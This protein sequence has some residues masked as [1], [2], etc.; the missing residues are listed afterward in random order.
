MPRSA[1]APLPPPVVR[2]RPL[3]DR[4]EVV[5]LDRGWEAA[6]APPDASPEPAEIDGLDWIPARVPGTA[7]G[8][9]AEAGRWRLGDP[10]D[11]DREDWW[12]RTA[13]DADPADTGEEALLRL[14]GLATVADVFLNGQRIARTDSM[15]APAAANVGTVLQRRNELAIRC[16][17]LTPLLAGRRRPRARWRTRLVDEPNLRFVRTT[18]LGRAPGYAPGPAPVGPWRPVRLERRRVVAVESLRVR[19]GATESG[20]SVHITARLRGLGGRRVDSVQAWVAGPDGDHVA[21]L[22]L[23]PDGE[24]TQAKGAVT[25]AAAP[26]WWPHTHGDP[27]TLDVRLHVQAGGDAAVVEGGRVGVRALETVR[28][29]GD[30]ER[31]GIALR[32]NGVPVFARGAV[33]TPADPVGFEPGGDAL[34]DA[35]DRVVEAGMNMLRIPGIGAYESDEFHDG[36]DD[37]GILVWQD[38]MYANLDYPFADAAFAEAAQAEAAGV[39]AR[40]AG[41]PSLA[42]V[43]GSS[44]IEQ[45][46]AMLGL[47]P[48][49]GRGEFFGKTVPAIV[50]DAGADAAYVPSAPCGGDLPFRTNRGIANYYGVGGYRRPLSDV[51]LAEVRFAAECLAFSNVPDAEAMDDIAPGTPSAL[52]AH[53]P[54][55]KAG[56]PRD[57]GSGWDF[58]DVRDHYLRNVFGVDP[59]ELRRID[60]G[61]YLELSR[62]VTGEIMAGVFG[63]WRRAGSPC[64]GALVLWLRDLRPGAGWGLLDH[65]GTPKA[66][67]HCLRRVLAPVAVWMTDEGLNGIDIHVANDR[68]E[69]LS[70]R[71]RVALYRDFEVR[72]DEGAINLDLPA[73]GTTVHG[74]EELLGRFVDASWSYRFGPP[75]HDAVVASLESG[76]PEHPSVQSQGFHFTRRRA[77]GTLPSADHG[78]SATFCGGDAPSVQVRAHRLLHGVTVRVPG[79]EA[80]DQHFCVEPGRMRPVRLRPLSSPARPQQ[81][82]VTASNLPGRLRLEVAENPAGPAAPG[83][84][85]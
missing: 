44:E 10:L 63:E 70:C 46:V 16:R 17:A 43:C 1:D 80:L 51:R 73:H 78:A 41:R 49:L 39:L 60:H 38:L 28:P 25:V 77:A 72:V 56:V 50:Q 47:D 81:G 15:Y 9:L 79:F 20:A 84:S 12:F 61:R 68:P 76:P 2:G 7:A 22:A 85:H 66:A 3:V 54:R 64:G 31:D 58:E 11:L 18:L 13:F 69:P 52:V 4:G 32:I 27:A 34:D 26:R 37:R 36:C 8:A 83:R 40:L 75:E 74:V 19:S 23:T 57:N 67:Y 29:G 48:A 82:H 65:C 24:C 14:E 62:A 30:L 21:S 53:H 55:W 42:V 35:L 6:S 45:Q 5:S 33:W 71:L 59:S